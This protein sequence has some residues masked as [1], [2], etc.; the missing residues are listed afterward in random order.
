MLELASRALLVDDLVLA[1]RFYAEILGNEV[2]GRGA[3]DSRYLLSTDE[4]LELRRRAATGTPT[5][6]GSDFWTNRPPYANVT[7]GRT[8]IS[9]Y[10]ADR[11]IQEPPPEQLRGLPRIAISADA[12]EITRATQVLA[13]HELPFEGPVQHPATC[14]AAQSLYFKDPAGNFLELCQLRAE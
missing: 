12:E 7:V 1:E 9:L 11:H 4:L 10:V 2:F 13:R 8:K 3:V 5:E 6:D 14:P